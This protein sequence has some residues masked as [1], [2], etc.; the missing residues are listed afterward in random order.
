MASKKKA[1]SKVE[2]IN[3]LLEQGDQNSLEAIKYLKEALV[4]YRKNGDNIG[5]AS[6]LAE[7]GKV[8]SNL[9]KRYFWESIFKGGIDDPSFPDDFPPMEIVGPEDDPS[10][11]DTKPKPEP[12]KIK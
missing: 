7:I 1:D 3:K 12:E 9:G 6:T 2:E 5:V 11:P 4:E 8:Y 10:F